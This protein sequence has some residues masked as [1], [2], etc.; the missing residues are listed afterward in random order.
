MAGGIE[1]VTPL[2][3]QNLQARVRGNMMLNWANSVNGLLLV[4]SNL[5]EAA[6]GYTTTGGD[7][8]GGY[9]PHR[10]CA[11]DGHQPAAR[12]SRATRQH[13]VAPRHTR[14]PAQRRTGPRPARRN[15][16]DAVR[17][18]RRPAVPVRQ[19]AHDARRMLARA[20]PPVS[21]ARRRATARL[22]RDF[23]KLF[24]QQPV[25]TRPAP[26]HHE[27]HRNST[28]T[29][30][31]ASASPSPKASRTNWT[32]SPA[33]SWNSKAASRNISPVQSVGSV[34]SCPNC[35]MSRPYGSLQRLR[36]LDGRN[37]RR[38]K[39]PVTVQ[40]VAEYLHLFLN[41]DHVA[42][43]GR[44]TKPGSLRV[45]DCDRLQ[46]TANAAAARRRESIAPC[47]PLDPENPRQMAQ[48]PGP[49]RW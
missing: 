48:P 10:Q 25:E 1:N 8:Q 28:S 41:V 21:R 45:P 47:E 11:E 42:R 38:D 33:P 19:T 31:P 36:L 15:R 29:Q 37:L 49:S 24:V 35:Q 30:K 9:S 12:V 5:S 16:P 20:V 7:N 3:R 27:S 13:Q 32:T 2:A 43:V 26:R 46:A 6:V 4:T 14:H 34:R 22:D 23:G 18:P 44:H 40:R 39:Q 17:H